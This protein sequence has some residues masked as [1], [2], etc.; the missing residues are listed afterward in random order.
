MIHKK[1]LLSL[2]L[3]SLTLACLADN[4]QEIILQE[5]AY[6]QYS[7]DLKCAR[8]KFTDE[9][10]VEFQTME[11]D[12]KVLSQEILHRLHA[13]IK[14]HKILLVTQILNSDEPLL[15]ASV[16]VNYQLPE[17]ATQLEERIISQSTICLKSPSTHF[18]AEEASEY[19]LMHDKIK[20][21]GYEASN[22]IHAIVQDHHN[23]VISTKTNFDEP[24][25]SLSIQI[26][27]Q[28][29]EKI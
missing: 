21:L 4:T 6:P 9:E 18:T 27:P 12:I 24:I 19:T 3:A 10:K 14:E 13:I 28:L 15:S 29:L 11:E 7:I 25:A 22:R 8:D 23:L 5:N 17:G 26:D 2:S 16:K 20:L 1:T